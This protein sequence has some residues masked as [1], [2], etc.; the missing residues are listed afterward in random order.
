MRMLISTY[1]SSESGSTA[2]EYA[3]ILAIVGLSLAVAMFALRDAI[4]HAMNTTT[5]LISN[6]A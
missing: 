1:F 6:P 2:A 5:A 3:L 4:A